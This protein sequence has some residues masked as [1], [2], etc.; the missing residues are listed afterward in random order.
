MVTITGTSGYGNPDYISS[1]VEIMGG[2]WW[3]TSLINGLERWLQVILYGNN[4]RKII[5]RTRK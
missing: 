4:F 5:N 1:V 3:G 2:V